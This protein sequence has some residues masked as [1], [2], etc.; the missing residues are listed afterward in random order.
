[1]DEGI[2]LWSPDYVES[3]GGLLIDPALFMVW[4]HLE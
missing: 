3:L 4:C 1:M 2:I